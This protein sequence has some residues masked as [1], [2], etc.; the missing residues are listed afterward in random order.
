MFIAG[1]ARSDR[2]KRGI[3]HK[4]ANFSQYEEI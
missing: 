1:D 4:Y 2:G 3:V